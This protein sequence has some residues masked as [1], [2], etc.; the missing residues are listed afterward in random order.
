MIGPAF[1]S[2]FAVMI[3]S[4]SFTIYHLLGILLTVFGIWVLSKS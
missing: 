2:A 3:L 1:T 4:E